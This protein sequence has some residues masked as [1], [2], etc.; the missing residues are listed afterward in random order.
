MVASRIRG[1]QA[2]GG[3]ATRQQRA[4]GKGGGQ[5]EPKADAIAR[6]AD[7]LVRATPPCILAAPGSMDVTVDTGVEAAWQDV[8]DDKTPTAWC[9]VI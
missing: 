7:E 5:A 4:G 1:A 2:P 8:M 9:T 3:R 6:A